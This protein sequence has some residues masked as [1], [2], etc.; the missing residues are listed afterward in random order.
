M[1][2]TLFIARAFRRVISAV[3]MNGSRLQRIYLM[4][5]PRSSYYP[6]LPRK[7]R[8]RIIWDLT[9]WLF[10]YKEINSF[11][12]LYGFDIAEPARDMS[13]Y[14]NY[15]S[16]IADRARGN[17]LG[18][19]DSQVVLLRDKYLFYKY[20]SCNGLPVPRV[21]AVMKNGA[22]Y[23]ENMNR[24]E[25]S[26][27]EEKKH[28]FIK[29]ISG[30]CASFVRKVSDFEEFRQ[31]LP[32]LKGDY[33]F[34]EAIKQNLEMNRLNGKAINTLRIVT[35]NK[36]GE[37]YPLTALLRVGTDHS[38]NVDNWAA[39][40][41]AVGIEEDGTLKERA[42]FKPVHGLSTRSHPDSGVV[43][44]SFKVPYFK[45][46]IRL[47]CKAHQ[48][49]YGV[50]TI[51]WDIA[52]EDAGPVFIEG[53]DNWEISLQQACDRPLRREWEEVSRERA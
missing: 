37:A 3:K 40:G 50:Q 26:V 8:S 47:S 43:F 30:E 16:F 14:Q 53:N 19:I 28:Y 12:N 33:I 9:R 41:L 13:Q 25:L 22:L 7:S 32:E 48:F 21:F 42:F 11:Y 24:I 10:R 36:N 1:S 39:G 6:E 52:I 15:R 27:L 44:S 51:G 2:K 20:M 17:K 45:E 5:D 34:Q 18:Q 23:D 31:L 4:T 29:D 38:G 49:F 46:A 35:I